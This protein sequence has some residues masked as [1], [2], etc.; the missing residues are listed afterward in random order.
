[1]GHLLQGY[2][3]VGERPLHYAIEA[4][5]VGTGG[6]LGNDA[7]VAFML[8]LRVD[9]IGEGPTTGGVEDGG[10]GVVARSFDGQDHSFIL[11]LSYQLFLRSVIRCFIHATDGSRRKLVA[12][13]TC[14]AFEVPAITD[15]WVVTDG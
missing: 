8:R 6:N 13:T 14:A 3:C 2:A 15:F 4:F 5:E 7:T 9:N 10:A 1:L 11:A 12:P